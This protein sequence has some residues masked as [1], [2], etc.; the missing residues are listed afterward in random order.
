MAPNPLWLT[1]LLVIGLSSECTVLLVVVCYCSDHLILFVGTLSFS[2]SVTEPL[3]SM[4]SYSHSESESERF[5]LLLSIML[6]IWKA[7]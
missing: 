2:E 7:S 4:G 5:L 6:R 1:P 3:L